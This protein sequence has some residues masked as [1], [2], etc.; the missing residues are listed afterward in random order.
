VQAGVYP[1]RIETDLNRVM[2]KELRYIG[3]YGYVWTTW[4]RSLR[5]LSEGRINTEPIISHE[6]PL[7]RFEEAFQVTQDGS[8][9]KVILN[10]QI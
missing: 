5:L 1:G 8:A 10:P 7:E 4:Q 6:F 3:I 9:V 2:M